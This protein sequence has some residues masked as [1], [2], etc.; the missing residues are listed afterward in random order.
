MHGTGE[1]TFPNGDKYTGDWNQGKRS[2]HGLYLYS[3]GNGY[4]ADCLLNRHWDQ[5][6]SI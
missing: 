2:G 5:R 4:T 3:N 1:M 6:L